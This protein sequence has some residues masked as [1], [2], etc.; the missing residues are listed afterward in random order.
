VQVAQPVKEPVRPEIAFDAAPNVIQFGGSTMLRWNLRNTVA[1]SIAP[2][3]GTLNRTTGQYSVSPATTTTYVLTARS[4]DGTT[5]TAQTVVQVTAPPRPPAPAPPSPTPTQG[6]TSAMIAVVHDHGGALNTGVWPGC[7]GILQVMNGNLRFTVAGA[8]DGRRDA[9][10][11][12]VNQLGEIKLNK[13]RIRNQPAFHIVVR[14]QH[15]N[16]VT[17]GMAAGQ[18]VNLLESAVSGR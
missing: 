16:F 17:T 5:A 18:A 14:G 2:G 4:Q 7:Y 8:T 6:A 15:L 1:A 12:P 3:P 10:E 13:L 9:F 11:V